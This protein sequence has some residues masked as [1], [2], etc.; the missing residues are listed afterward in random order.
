MLSPAQELETP[1]KG[2]CPYCRGSGDDPGRKPLTPLQIRLMEWIHLFVKA[3]RGVMPTLGEI[4]IAFNWR[5]LSTAHEHVQNLIAKGFLV[6]LPGMQNTR[7]SFDLV[8][9]PE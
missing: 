3:N 2:C 5:S 7:R 8:D 9:V 6:K 4:C 1:R